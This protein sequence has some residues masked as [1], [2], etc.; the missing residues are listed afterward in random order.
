M[1]MSVGAQLGN[2]KEYVNASNILSELTVKR[3]L[4]PWI[5]PHFI[6]N[7]S[8]MGKIYKHN[9]NITHSMSRNV[10]NQRKSE[11]LADK[12]NSNE[13]QEI[14]S[15]E[16]NNYIKSKKRL[17]FLD[18]LLEHHLKD[19]TLSLEDIREEV[20]LFMFAGSGS[21]ATHLYWTLYLLGLYP[22]VQKRVTDELESIFGEQIDR[23][24]TFAD[25]QKMHYLECVIKESLRLFPP[26]PMINR[27]LVIDLKIGD[28]LIP[29]GEHIWIDIKNLHLDPQIFPE[30]N[31]FKPERFENSNT[32]NINSYSFIPFSAGPRDCIGKRFAMNSVKIVLSKILFNFEIRSL[33]PIDK[34]MAVWEVVYRPKDP[35]RVQYIPKFKKRPNI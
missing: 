14:K 24:I 30:P 7:M 19:N 26:I 23:D 18:L 34:V 6:F 31:L 21:T 5:W 3:I 9:I 15:S 20:D 25:L 17:A 2:N 27:Q 4:S 10:I 1:G 13:K 12:K 35:L 33:D 22:S 8:S 16:E 32:S 29:K 28:Y 11:L